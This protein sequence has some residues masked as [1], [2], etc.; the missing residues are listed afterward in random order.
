MRMIDEKPNIRVARLKNPARAESHLSGSLVDIAYVLSFTESIVDLQVDEADLGVD[1]RS[2][3]DREWLTGLLRQL[4]N[5]CG[6]TEATITIL[7]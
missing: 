1:L 4:L 2:S 7:T 6:E 5:D 3:E